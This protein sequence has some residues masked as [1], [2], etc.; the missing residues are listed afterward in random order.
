MRVLSHLPPFLA[1]WKD[2][3]S[4][5]CMYS[6]GIVKDWRLEHLQDCA[7]YLDCPP[8]ECPIEEAALK[9]R[10]SVAT[11]STPIDPDQDQLRIEA[12]ASR[13][14]P[15]PSPARPKRRRGKG[16]DSP[17]KHVDSTVDVLFAQPPPSQRGIRKPKPF[18]HPYDVHLHPGLVLSA[19]RQKFLRM[20]PVSLITMK[21]A[22]ETSGVPCEAWTNLTAFLTLVL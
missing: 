17:L 9:Q 21:R 22:A 6:A 16:A 15:L 5:E 12:A 14:P 8:G 11:L 2:T 20:D 18:E 19:T 1:A 13:E 4:D 10:H 3:A 7:W